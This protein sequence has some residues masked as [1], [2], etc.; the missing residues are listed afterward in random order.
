[1]SRIPSG[2][3]RCS[4]SASTVSPASQRSN[5]SVVVRITGMALG[6][7]GATMALAV[8]VRNPNCSCSRTGTLTK[9]DLRQLVFLAGPNVGACGYDEMVMG[10]SDSFI[11]FREFR[12]AL[13]PVQQ[14][15]AFLD[16]VHGG[17]AGWAAIYPHMVRSPHKG[18]VELMYNVVVGNAALP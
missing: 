6:W 14:G 5:S 1:M 11:R 17:D 7:M 8:V 13:C 16:L 10:L 12:H 15:N 3:G 4:L 2:N 18:N 9:W